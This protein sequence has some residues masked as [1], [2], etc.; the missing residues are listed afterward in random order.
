M[1][2]TSER[3][4][5]L[6]LPIGQHKSPGLGIQCVGQTTLGRLNRDQSGLRKL[7]PFLDT[8]RRTLIPYPHHGLPISS[9]NA[10]S[11]ITSPVALIDFVVDESCS[12]LWAFLNHFRLLQMS[13]PPPFHCHRTGA[14]LVTT[15]LT[16]TRTAYGN[17]RRSGP[18]I[19]HGR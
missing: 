15:T 10:I 6:T 2:F 4:C 17:A 14:T 11:P 13:S 9:I 18:R 12:E 3:L 16:T 5:D 19:R 7:N 1:P 8:T